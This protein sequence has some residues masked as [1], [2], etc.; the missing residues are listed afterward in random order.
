MEKEKRKYP[1]PRGAAATAAKNKYRDK[2]YDRIE[3]AMPKGTKKNILEAVNALGYRSVNQF[4]EKAVIEK[5][6]AEM[7]K[8]WEITPPEQDIV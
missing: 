5:Y 6:E 3:L 4:I 8:A 1:T 2:T 7:D